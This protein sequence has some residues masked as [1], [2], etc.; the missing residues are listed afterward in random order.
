MAQRFLEPGARRQQIDADQ[1]HWCGIGIH[2]VAAA[3]LFRGRRAELPKDVAT[4]GRISPD[5][6]LDP[7]T[8]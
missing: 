6:Q 4:A 1:A 7:A 2:A 5:R 3:S 8:D